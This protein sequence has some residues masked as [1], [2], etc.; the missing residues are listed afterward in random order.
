MRPR[1]T[2]RATGNP[3]PARSLAPVIALAL[4]AALAASWPLRAAASP[5]PSPLTNEDIVRMLMT[6]TPENEVLATIEARRVDFD[7]STEMIHELRTA[8]VSDR[9]LETMRRRQASMPRVEPPPLPRPAP[10]RTGTLRLE[11]AAGDEGDKPSELSAIALRKLPK[12]LERRGGEEVGEM[13]DMALAILCTTAD[14]VP[15][16]W[17]TR[18]PL[19]GAPRHELL[20][21]IPGSATE[22]IKGH[23]ILYLDRKE[24][25]ELELVAGSHNIV[26]AAA[27]KQSGSG[28]W[29][30]I[31]SDGARVT[32]LPGRQ[33]RMVLRARSRIKGT[34]MMGFSVDSEWRIVSVDVPEAVAGPEARP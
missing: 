18:S 13:S 25:Y 16:H 34:F 31:E 10:E 3:A 9:V 15:D 1:G 19:Q 2:R 24:S 14:H 29:R 30:L 26:V 33:T 11:F 4:L 23:E 12:G 6:G 32:V 22:K 21:F 7:L 20:Q 28:T 8:G 5:H 17:D 27:G